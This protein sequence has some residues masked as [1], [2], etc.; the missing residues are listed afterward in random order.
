MDQNKDIL[1]S[2][3]LEE[4][5]SSKK[6]DIRET[7]FADYSITAKYI[8]NYFV[9]KKTSEIT[10]KSIRDFYSSE[11]DRGLTANT[12]KHRHAV[13]NP[14]LDFALKE[15]RIIDFNPATA[16]K[17]PKKRK[18]I[19]SVI[20][21]EVIK[22]I[23]ED[24]KDTSMEFPLF[25]AAIYGLRRSEVIGIKWEAFDLKNKV[26]TMQNTIIRKHINGTIE[27]FERTYGKNNS[28]YRQF[29]I[30]D[31]LE[32]LLSRIKKNHENYKKSIPYYTTHDQEYLC[33]N[34]EGRLLNPEFLTKKF[35]KI[36]KKL[37]LNSSLRFHD[38]R[39]SCATFLY[40]IGIEG[41]DIQLWL[42]HSDI[43]TTLNIYT[44]LNFKN[45]ERTASKLKKIF[46][47][48]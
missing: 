12:V 5:L 36:I 6:L 23:L 1:F 41:K 31:E 34:E 37:N 3:L 43:G 4:W 10:V 15:L 13:I 48:K 42:G 14:A 33:L 2:E 44:H 7:T 17:L 29:P 22:L 9:G 46:E 27:K 26:F 20:D 30:I 38:L 47:D 24:Q 25:M 39:H 35:K 11:L 28:S 16:I 18:Y 8:A 40:N 21:L 45:K 19:H 32:N